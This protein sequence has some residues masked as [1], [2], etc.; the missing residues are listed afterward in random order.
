MSEVIVGV[1]GMTVDG[2]G[3]VEPVPHNTSMS[4]DH[5]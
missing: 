2:E 5:V 1:F 3:V 4:W